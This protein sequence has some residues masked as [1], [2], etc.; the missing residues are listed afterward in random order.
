MLVLFSSFSPCFIQGQR[1]VASRTAIS[2][3][4][5]KASGRTEEKQ[6]AEFLQGMVI[7]NHSLLMICLQ[8]KEIEELTSQISKTAKCDKDNSKPSDQADGRQHRT[9]H[10]HDAEEKKLVDKSPLKT[11]KLSYRQMMISS[12]NTQVYLQPTNTFL[13]AVTFE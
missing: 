12:P 2:A 11:A 5:G 10:P 6:D 9:H 4:G 8:D 7:S 3:G 13:V 1:A